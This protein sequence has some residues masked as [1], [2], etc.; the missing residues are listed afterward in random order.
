MSRRVVKKN[1]RPYHGF[2]WTRQ[3]MIAAIQMSSRLLSASPPVTL[4][5]IAADLSSRELVP[6]R[7]D[8]AT[9]RRMLASPEARELELELMRK[10]THGKNGAPNLPALAEAVRLEEEPD[11][12][13]RREGGQ[14]E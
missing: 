2:P 12:K 6:Y 13:P 5:T 7:P 4:R 11:W 1:A 10:L 3:A 9:V 14:T 8:P